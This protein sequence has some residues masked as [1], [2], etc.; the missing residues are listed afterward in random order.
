[1]VSSRAIPMPPVG[2]FTPEP[3]PSAEATT[4]RSPH[5]GFCSFQVVMWLQLPSL[6]PSPWDSR[7]RNRDYKGN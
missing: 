1:M 4:S 6:T 5:I 3:F 7:I 2:F